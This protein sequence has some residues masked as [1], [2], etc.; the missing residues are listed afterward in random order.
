MNRASPMPHHESISAGGACA[1]R[2]GLILVAALGT[3]IAVNP[4]A[5]QPAAI[6]GF[7]MA[8]HDTGN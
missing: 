5:A 2:T 4:A 7:P 8:M 1:Y 3:G 6:G